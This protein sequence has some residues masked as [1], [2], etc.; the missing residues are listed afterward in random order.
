M[1]RL[2]NIARGN[3]RQS[4]KKRNKKSSKIVLK[5]VGEY[6]YPQILEEVGAAPKHVENMES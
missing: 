6:R 2:E 5:D 4:E 3:E 1:G